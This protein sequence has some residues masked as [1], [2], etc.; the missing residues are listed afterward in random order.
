MT[1]KDAYNTINQANIVQHGAFEGVY[2]KTVISKNV[3]ISRVKCY[4]ATGW[5]LNCQKT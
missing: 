1:T 3:M 5:R 2:L 4:I